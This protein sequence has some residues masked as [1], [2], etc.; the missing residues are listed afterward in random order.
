ML[1][2]EYR[3][4]SA[5][6]IKMEYRIW[7]QNRPLSHNA[8]ERIILKITMNIIFMYS[9]QDR[10]YNWV[11]EPDSAPNNIKNNDEYNSNQIIQP[12]RCNS[13]TSLLLYVYAWLNMFQVTPRP[14]SGAY[15]CT[16]SL[17]FYRWREA[18]G[19]LLVI[20]NKL[21]KL[22]HLVGWITWIVWWCTDLGKSNLWIWS[23]SNLFR[24]ESTIAW[25]SRIVLQI[26]LTHSVNF[27]SKG[28]L[29]ITNELWAPCIWAVCKS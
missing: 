16:R 5:D 1:T 28:K 29:K 15:N 7:E 2:W 20:S 14:S 4:I 18:A 12:T 26:I 10:V 19:A 25:L 24:I 8:E 13:F 9:V 23:S 27:L 11:A 6:K 3:F 22:L 17:W 21:V